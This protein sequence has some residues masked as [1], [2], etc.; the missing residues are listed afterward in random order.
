MMLAIFGT[1]RTVLNRGV[2]VMEAAMRGGSSKHANHS[3]VSQGNGQ[4][5]PGF[6]SYSNGSYIKH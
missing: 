3:L 1:K 4:P 2:C 6:G 5:P